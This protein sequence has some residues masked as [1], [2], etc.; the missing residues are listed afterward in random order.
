MQPKKITKRD[1]MAKNYF[2]GVL[3]G[4]GQGTSYSSMEQ[5]GLPD[6]VQPMGRAKISLYADIHA[7]SLI[8]GDYV[9]QVIEA[10]AALKF[11][12]TYKDLCITRPEFAL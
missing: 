11:Y 3:A 9:V 6:V 8:I 5:I 1:S 4:D 2:V 7:R 12:Y 10:D